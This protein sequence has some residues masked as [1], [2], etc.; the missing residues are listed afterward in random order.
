MGEQ[1]CL[2]LRLARFSFQCEF[3]FIGAVSDVQPI[4]AVEASDVWD[5]AGLQKVLSALG[6]QEGEF[7]VTAFPAET[8]A[9]V[10]EDFG[11]AVI[12]EEH[13]APDFAGAAES[14]DS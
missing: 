11:S 5:E 14:R 13:I 8:A 7:E 10:Q 2:D 3:S 12:E 6:L 9:K 4:A 1:D